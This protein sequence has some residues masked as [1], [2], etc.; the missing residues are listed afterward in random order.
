[1]ATRLIGKSQPELTIASEEKRSLARRA[2][3]SSV[4]IA[5][6]QPGG[7]DLLKAKKQLLPQSPRPVAA[8]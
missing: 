3:I 8:K 4:V 7:A 1:M 5:L 2:P 6:P